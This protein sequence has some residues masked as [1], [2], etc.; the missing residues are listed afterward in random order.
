[1][2]GA[3][4]KIYFGGIPRLH[5]VNVKRFLIAQRWLVVFERPGFHVVPRFVFIK[6]KLAHERNLHAK[7][8]G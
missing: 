5:Q 8:F 7:L 6:V 2:P 1:M 3:C 4:Q